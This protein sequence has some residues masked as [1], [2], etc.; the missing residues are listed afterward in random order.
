MKVTDPTFGIN[1]QAL[2]VLAFLADREIEGAITAT[3]P[4]YNC[5]ERGVTFSI[6]SGYVD[7]VL[8][9]AVF[10][11]RNSD[12]LHALRWEDEMWKLNPP[13]GDESIERA[14]PTDSKY[15]TAFNVPYGHIGKMAEWVYREL[16][17]FFLQQVND[18]E[19]TNHAKA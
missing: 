15:D 14:Y 9:I 7:S 8:R 12:S 1:E 10:E 5:R 3:S 6:S 19:E 2:A 18:K 4:W 17:E 16:E 13:I 11:Q